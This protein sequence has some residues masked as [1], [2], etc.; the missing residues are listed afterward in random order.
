MNI[1][2]RAELVVVGYAVR[3]S[4]ADE[5][6]PARARL[7]ALWQRA[8]APGPSRMCPAAWTRISTPC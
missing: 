2:E 7:P 4:N 6:D 8:G 3:T 1:T 5:M